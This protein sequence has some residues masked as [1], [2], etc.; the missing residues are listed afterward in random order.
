MADLVGRNDAAISTDIRLIEKYF[1]PLVE[2][3]GL[4]VAVCIANKIN[5]SCLT[6]KLLSGRSA[7]YDCD[8]VEYN[9]RCPG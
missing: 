3:D 4:E 1:P 7:E 6:A 5:R 2:G 8:G 9:G